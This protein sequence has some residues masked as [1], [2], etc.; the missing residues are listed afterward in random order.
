MPCPSLLDYD[1]FKGVG[2]SSSLNL[3]EQPPLRQAYCTHAMLLLSVQG[4]RAIT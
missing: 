2:C 1:S 3:I 4:V